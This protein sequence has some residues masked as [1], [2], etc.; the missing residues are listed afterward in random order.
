MQV[1]ANMTAGASAL[2]T[3]W[4]NL[5]TANLTAIG[6]WTSAKVPGKTGACVPETMR[7]NGNGYYGDGSS[8]NNDSCDTTTSPSYNSQTITTGA[9]VALAMWQ[10][11]Q[12][13]GDTSFLSGAYPL[14]KAA[15]QFLLSYATVGGD[16]KLH[17]TAN[18]HETQWAVSDPVTDVDAMKALFPAVRSAA[19]VL[20]LDTTFQSQLATAISQTR[21]WPR[22]D[23]ATHSQVL[24]ASSDAG[25]Q[26]VMALS[27]NPTATQHN[28]ENLDLEATYPYGL[29]G[30]SSGT[31]T[32]LEKRTYTNRLYRNDADWDYDSLYAARLGLSSEVSADLIATTEKYQLLPSGMASLFA[33]A[34]SNEPYNE[35]SGI[36][37]ATLNE[38]LAQDYD[39]LL[40][41]AP[42]W[43]STWDVDGQV[44]IQNKS[45][46]DVQVRNG[47][48]STVV[49]EAGATASMLVRSPWSG[50][51]VQVLDATSGTTTVA[52]TTAT[53]FTI[54]ATAGHNYLIEQ[55]ASP[56]TNLPY[57]QIT[58]APATAPKHLGPVS[59]GT[60]G[61]AAEGPY[62]GSATAVPGTV[63]AE[64]YDTGGQGVAYNVSSVNGNGTAYRSD[65]VDLETTS[66]TG[67]GD[68]LGWTS[69]GQWF[70][71]TV[72]AATAGVYTVS[73]RVAAPNAVT[74]GLHIA[75]SSGTNLSGNVNI[76]SSGGW[77]TWETVTA[78]VTLPAGQQVLTLDEDN[79]GWNANSLQFTSAGSAEGPYGGS[80]AAVPG[81]VQTENYD[82]GGAGIAY[83]VSSVNGN[84]TAYRNDGVDLET[85]SDTGGGDDLGWTTGG[86]WFR[87][88]VNVATAGVYTVSFRVAAP[89]AVTDGLHI[90]SESGANLSGN[91]NI[92]ASGG[93]QTWETVTAQV[94]LPAG[95]QVLTLAE[96]NG[97]WNANWLQ[98]A[99]A[100]GGGSAT[101]TVSPSTL[102]FA[103]QS[104]GTTSATQSVTVTN[105]GTAAA[106]VSA[107]ATSGDFAQTN[108]CGATIGAGG[109][110]SVTVKFTPTA[111]GTRTGTLTV[112]S[113]ATNSPGTAALSGTGATGATN[114]AQGK[115]T[116]ESSHTDVYASSN[117]TDGN[118]STYWESTDNVFPSWVQVDL[119]SAQSAGRVVLQLPASWGAR[120]ET[121]SLTASTDGTNFTTVSASAGRTFDPAANGDAVTIT[122]PAASYRY[123]RVTITAN[124]G[125]PAGQL[126]EFQVW[127]Q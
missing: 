5:Y 72:N 29:I 88:T 54:P 3:R 49:L 102:T 84:G 52:S 123:W 70:R 15:A 19:Q 91:V 34:N 67:G 14:M 55:T 107:I 22:T 53:T 95:Q 86:Q 75:N 42:A 1:D 94:T 62:G 36:V 113:N 100:G 63:Q 98:F 104:V 61:G 99:S 110:C 39:G 9:E 27:T 80:A 81:T 82:T 47:V 79:G 92:P 77:Q 35:E 33:Q 76:P 89:N 57:A 13:T 16:G 4:F 69:G 103:S 73:F 17:E 122:F 11:Y 24:T 120:T 106:S 90:A 43:P 126:S 46:V 32:D 38:S 127:N 48:P 93:W 68:D 2:N 108:T 12:M 20:G 40:R 26:D 31:L 115:A 116:S 83:T 28:T 58:G 8:S 44:S 51:A 78:Q 125:W 124:T 87:Y 85:T 66:D 6:N 7:F 117:V 96:D 119:G 23:A 65:G 71:Y 56:F 97:G 111:S 109:N 41:I 64:N 112:T 74:D 101:L 21:D 59:I 114:L 60:G 10:Q 118:Q 121:L 25:G 37:A 45:K 18:A 30:D 50:Q 105:T